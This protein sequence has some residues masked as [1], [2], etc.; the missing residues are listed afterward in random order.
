MDKGTRNVKSLFNKVKLLVLDVDGVLTKGE[1]I[2]GNLGEE[3][4]IFNVKDGLGVFLLAKSGI[5]TVLLTAK[6][7]KVVRRRAK[8]MGVD[9]YAGVLPKE[10]LLCKIR[11]KYNV[12][13]KNICFVGDDL[14]DIGIMRRVGIPVAVADAPSE[15]KK[16]SL[17]VT[18]KRG[19]KGAAR[20]VVEK[21]LKSKNMWKGAIE[22]LAFLSR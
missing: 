10:S 11:R 13:D 20:E 19:G 12:S 17:Y 1:V 6:D 21:I 2:Y 18:R 3:I 9:I 5:K 7:S 22:S 16:A 8:D 4:K 14:I 15:V